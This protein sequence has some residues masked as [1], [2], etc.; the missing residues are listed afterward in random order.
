MVKYSS[1]PK[2][3]ILEKLRQEISKKKKI[4]VAR[5]LYQCYLGSIERP[6]LSIE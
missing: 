3:Q 6:W 5:H 4:R 1:L 2:I